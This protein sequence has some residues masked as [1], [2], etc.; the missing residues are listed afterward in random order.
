MVMSCTPRILPVPELPGT[1]AEGRFAHVVLAGC[2]QRA[3]KKGIVPIQAAADH[4]GLGLANCKGTHISEATLI[5]VWGF[6]MHH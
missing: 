2:G 5:L 3:V 6:G 4:L 1:V